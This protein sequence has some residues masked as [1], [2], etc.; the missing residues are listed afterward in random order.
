MA[1]PE[2]YERIDYGLTA[3][4]IEAATGSESRPRFVYLSAAGAREGTQNPYMQARVRAEA[5][6]RSSGLPYTIVRPSFIS[7]PDR[8]ESR[9]AE[10]VAATVGDGALALA[11][12][13]GAKKLRDRYRSISAEALGDGLV[14]LALDDAWA[15]RIAHAEALR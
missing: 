2:A 4:L 8:D 7:G 1:A 6:L 10:R 15:G 3:L 9:P 12:A 14:R 13:L 11:G 5:D